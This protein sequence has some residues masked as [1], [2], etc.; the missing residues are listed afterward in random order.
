MS[1]RVLL[2]RRHGPHVLLVE[3]RRDQW[4]QR[5]QDDRHRDVEDE[6]PGDLGAAV[7]GLGLGL[8][9]E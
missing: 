2:Q 5:P 8:G 9:L 7:L 1:L 6:P 3:S 4:P